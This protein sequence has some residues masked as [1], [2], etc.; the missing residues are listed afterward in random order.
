[1]FKYLSIFVFIASS[2]LHSQNTLEHSSKH[3]I[4][5]TIQKSLQNI[6]MV[7]TLPLLLALFN[8]KTTEISISDD[9]N[10]IGSDTYLK[11]LQRN[12]IDI[13]DPHNK[14]RKDLEA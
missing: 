6:K 14:E 12:D 7:E 4:L 10:Q 2:V 3:Q 13:I 8:R 1:M 5:D 9:S 11:K